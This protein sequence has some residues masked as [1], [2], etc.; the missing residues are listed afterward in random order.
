MRAIAFLRQIR[1]L[2]TDV[3]LELSFHNIEDYRIIL[4]NL[5][6]LLNGIH[7]LGFDVDALLTVQQCFGEELAKIKVLDILSQKI[8]AMDAATVPTLVNFLLNW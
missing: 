3:D 2:L 5:L 8:E 4:A 6:P 7:S 1:A